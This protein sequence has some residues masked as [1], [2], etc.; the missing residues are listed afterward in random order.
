MIWVLAMPCLFKTS[1]VSLRANEV[2]P[3]ARLCY[4]PSIKIEPAFWMP[5]PCLSSNPTSK[6]AS[7]H[8]SMSTPYAQPPNILA[9]SVLPPSQT[10][11]RP[12]LSLT[13][14][15]LLQSWRLLSLLHRADLN[16]EPDVEH[17]LR[18]VGTLT[19]RQALMSHL[20][21]CPSSGTGPEPSAARTRPPT[22][23]VR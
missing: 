5:P 13:C 3:A 7:F 23:N 8:G 22:L 6:Q 1:S 20:P 14:Q 15:C 12:P 21:S 9:V 18:L 10:L 16:R 2:S 17:K 4:L 19:Q 11:F